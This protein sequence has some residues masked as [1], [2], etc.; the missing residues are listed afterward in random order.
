MTQLLNT[1]AMIAKLS[2]SNWPA[3]KQDP[4]LTA[5][6]IQRYKANTKVA[7]VNKNLIN[8]ENLS[9]IRQVI[10]E[11]RKWHD[12]LTLPWGDHGDRLLPVDT[13]EEYVKRMDDCVERL[14]QERNDFLSQY[15]LLIEDAKLMLGG[16]FSEGDYPSRAEVAGKFNIAYVIDPVPSQDHFLVNLTESHAKWLKA[17]LEKRNEIRLNNAIVQLYERIEDALTKLVERLGFHEDGKPRRL[18]ATALETLREIA[19]IVPSMNLVQ[20]GK[21]N[22][23]AERIS[24]VLAGVEIDD[25]RQKSKVKWKVER[26]NNRRE[27]LSKELNDIAMSYFGT[28]PKEPQPADIHR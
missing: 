10:A 18:H 21:L 8:K 23:I 12:R 26:T 7:R 11:A 25:L 4:I 3:T 20:D 24:S 6:L 22:T 14:E 1:K 5:D 13:H 17:D 16:M 28:N 27:T 19:E 2:V 9:N 15:E